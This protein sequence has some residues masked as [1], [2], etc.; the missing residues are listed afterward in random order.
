M[1][2]PDGFLPGGMAA[3]TGAAAAVVLGYSHTK[4]FPRVESERVV[5]LGAV[6][7]LIFA[8]QMVNFAITHGT[9]GHFVGGA[10]AA[11]L[12]GPFLASILMAVLLVVQMAVFQDGG[13]L[14][15]GANIFN[16]G[17]VGTFGGYLIYV[18]LKKLVAGRY[19]LLIGAFAAGWFAV[20][21]AATSCAL[22]LGISGLSPVPDLLG[23][24]LAVHV[25]IGVAEGI[26]SLLLIAVV[27]QMQPD[28][29]GDAQAAGGGQRQL[30]WVFLLL[31]LV[32]GIAGSPFS[33]R[34]PDGLE[35]VAIDHGFIEKGADAF[36]AA[37]VA[38][39][40]M[41]F[42]VNERAA[43]AVSGFLGVLVAF[44]S[45][46]GVGVILCKR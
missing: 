1:H 2:I 36:F 31:A 10:F 29:L 34:S 30:W 7:A 16:M 12:F 37:P 5:A 6:A 40:R 4:T 43:T 9:S 18:L 28:L 41:P 19:G 35:R 38:E 11:I 32:V 21:L 25:K 44:G 39:Y 24:M 3:V 15:L 8:A 42:V 22:Q 20:V 45:M 33:S 46:A 13:L 26:L 27:L 14:A 17:I 23:S